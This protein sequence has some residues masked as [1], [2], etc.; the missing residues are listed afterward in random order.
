MHDPFFVQPP[1]FALDAEAPAGFIY[2]PGFITA[3][4]DADL[5]AAIEALPFGD[6]RMHG[7]VARRRVVQFGW[8]YSFDARQ[9]TAG[10][11]VPAFLEPLQARAAELIDREP[12]ALSEVLVTEYP[13]GAAIGWHRDAPPF[14]TIVGVS[15]RAACTFRFRRGEGEHVERFA[16]TLEP[17]SAYVLAG[18]ARSAW[19]HSIPPVRGLRYSITFRT[20][21]GHP[22]D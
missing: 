1:L 11:P 3:R 6:V 22:A 8:R 12:A 21:R 5:L 9:L 4:E 7:V 16:Q 13:P 2:R 15:L 19:Q 20:L 18:E 10:E 17:R 14:G